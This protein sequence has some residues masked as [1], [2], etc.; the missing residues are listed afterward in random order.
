MTEP[1]H[2]IVAQ[3]IRKMR[4]EAGLKQTDISKRMGVTQSMVSKFESGERRLDLVE[5]RAVCLAC[6]VSLSDFVARVEQR[7]REPG[8]ARG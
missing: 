8:H 1:H 5:I 6:G 4:I 7:L 2:R 3:L